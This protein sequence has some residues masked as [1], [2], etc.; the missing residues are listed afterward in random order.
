MSHDD[1]EGHLFRFLVQ[2]QG[3]Y[4]V[5]GVPGYHDSAEWGEP[6]SIE[7]RAWDLKSAARKAAERG[8]IGWDQEPRNALA[9]AARM[10]ADYRAEQGKTVPPWLHNLANTKGA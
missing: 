9:V 7:V 10:V 8:M 3:R 4:S 6:W 5:T 1:S 2:S